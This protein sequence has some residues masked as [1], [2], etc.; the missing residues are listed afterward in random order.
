MTSNQIE[1]FL[2]FLRDCE[3]RYHMAEAD[4]QEANAITNDILHALELKEN[5]EAELL[6]LVQELG[7]ARRQRRKAKDTMGET[8]PVREWM[9]ENRAVVKRLERLLGDVRKAERYAENR[10]Y[11]P[12]RPGT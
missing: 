4:E 1:A 8:L 10:I 11:T 6:R 3:Q 12:R 7:Q 2:T 9:D 5:G